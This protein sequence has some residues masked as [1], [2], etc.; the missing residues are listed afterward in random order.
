MLLYQDF[1]EHARPVY[2]YVPAR[3]KAHDYPE[4]KG[5]ENEANWFLHRIITLH[6]SF[7]DFEFVGIGSRSLEE[8]IHPRR[9]SDV[10]TTLI[11]ERIVECDNK[12]LT[13][14]YDVSG[15]GKCLGYKISS[16]Y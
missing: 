12:Y 3:F 8:F 4:L 5:V 13:A 14:A 16:G 7:K 2:F 15:R 9:V 10:K 11:K 1:P 6:S